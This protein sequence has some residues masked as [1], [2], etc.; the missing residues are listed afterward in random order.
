M[1][2]NFNFIKGAIPSHLK[3]PEKNNP[4]LKTGAVAT[5]SGVVR[6]DRTESADV[7]GIEFSAHEDMAKKVCLNL[8]AS[9]GNKFGLHSVR[10]IHSLGFVNTGDECF[11]VEVCS[12]HRKEA[13]LALPE[14]VD[15]FKSQ[16]PIFGKEFLS[17]NKY[18][19]KKNK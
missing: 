2:V 12:S 17:N 9:A 18:V 13:F 8:M 11:F 3:Q 16:M 5:F 15:T 7:T 6:K 4:V 14:I 19:W 10:I 1:N